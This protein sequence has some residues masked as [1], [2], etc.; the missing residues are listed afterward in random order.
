MD[1]SLG[2][3]E[4]KSHFALRALPAAEDGDYT[5]LGGMLATCLGRI[6]APA[7]PRRHATPRFRGMLATCLG[8]I[9]AE[10]DAVE[11]EGVRFEVL[12]MDGLRVDKI[13]V[14]PAGPQE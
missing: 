4:I 10:G 14:R 1:G 6:P 11:W 13:L 7:S 3:D 12:D 2:T 5:T 8:R 9:P